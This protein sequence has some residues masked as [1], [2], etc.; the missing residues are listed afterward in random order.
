M[1]RDPLGF[2]TTHATTNHPDAE[3][4]E[5]GCGGLMTDIAGLT[6]TV[7]C[8]GGFPLGPGVVG[9]ARKKE[10]RERA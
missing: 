3:E 10:E 5:G 8:A 6:L 7:A 1:E 2:S 4:E 9:H